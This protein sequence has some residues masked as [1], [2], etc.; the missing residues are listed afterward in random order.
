M[1]A[2]IFLFLFFHKNQVVIYNLGKKGELIF[3]IF[4]MYTISSNVIAILIIIF[5]F[6]H[7]SVLVSLINFFWSSEI[8]I[9]QGLCMPSR[10]FL[11][12][13]STSCSCVSSIFFILVKVLGSF[14]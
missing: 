12:S 6:F 13:Y 2:T 1:V 5:S 14:Q 9:R 7:F 8:K 4:S 3:F 11:K 10:Y